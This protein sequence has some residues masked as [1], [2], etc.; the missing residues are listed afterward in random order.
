MIK[1]KDN[2]IVCKNKHK[3]EKYN[4]SLRPDSSIIYT[5]LPAYPVTYY[6]TTTTTT[7]ATDM[8]YYGDTYYK[9]IK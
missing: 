3:Y 2:R 4:V 6:T 8:I 5:Y 7:T 9:I 1:I